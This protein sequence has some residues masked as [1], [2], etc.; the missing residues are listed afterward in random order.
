M[1]KHILTAAFL[2]VSI[3]AATAQN[4]TVDEH[5]NLH[6]KPRETTLRDSTTTKTYTDPKGAVH[7]VY[8]GA[9]GALYIG[10]VS[11]K[12]TY[13]RRYLNTKK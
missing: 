4:V 7:P 10:V 8:K 9:K 13:Y 3:F 11:K 2:F 1:K 6:A 5:G 12:G